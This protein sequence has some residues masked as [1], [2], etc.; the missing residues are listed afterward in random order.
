MPLKFDRDC[1]LSVDY[2]GKYSH[3]DIMDSSN[4]RIWYL[5]SSVYGVFDFFHLLMVAFCIWVFCLFMWVY[6]EVF[7]FFFFCIGEWDCFLNFSF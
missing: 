7:Y 5:S 1:I 6:S 3:F 4:P 2:F